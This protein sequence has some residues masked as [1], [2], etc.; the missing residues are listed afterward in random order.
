MR[1]PKSLIVFDASLSFIMLLLFRRE[2]GRKRSKGEGAEDCDCI[3]AAERF[4]ESAGEVGVL[5]PPPKKGTRGSVGNLGETRLAAEGSL[6]GRIDRE[7]CRDCR[8]EED[9]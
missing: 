1:N 7:D 8:F 9:R 2:A 3:C 5:D 4:R 6:G